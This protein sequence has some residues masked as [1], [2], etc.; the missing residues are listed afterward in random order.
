LLFRRFR[1]RYWHVDDPLD[2]PFDNPFDGHKHRHIL[3]DE[4]DLHARHAL[5]DQVVQ[6]R[7]QRDQQ[8]QQ[9]KKPNV[10]EQASTR[11][12]PTA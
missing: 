7:E 10:R 3:R 12:D 4:A 9:R 5:A 1:R 8:R 2:N 11:R 6:P